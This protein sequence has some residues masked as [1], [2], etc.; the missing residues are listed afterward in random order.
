[1]GLSF[2]FPGNQ[3]FAETLF[4]DIAF[5]PRKIGLDNP[6]KRAAAEMERFGLAEEIRGR[7]PWELSEGQQRL[8]GLAGVLALDPDCIIF[9]EPS[10][11][12]DPEARRRFVETASS[13]LRENRAL[14]M[15]TH[16]LETA[17]AVCSR[18]VVLGSGKIIHRGGMDDLMAD[19]KL[20][21]SLGL[22]SDQD[23][24]EGEL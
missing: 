19:R 20:R 18:A 12:L 6:E 2:Q 13:L 8:V 17:A 21:I 9:D 14:A 24:F 3:L 4:D 16:D 23:L 7:S 5:G 11:T 22:G 15:I 1:M 10:A